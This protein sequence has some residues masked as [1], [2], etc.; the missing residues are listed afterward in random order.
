[1]ADAGVVANEVADQLENAADLT[2]NINKLDWRIPGAFG[3]GA[4]VGF[5]AGYYFGLRKVRKDIERDIDLKYALKLDQALKDIKQHYA[6]KHAEAMRYYR[7]KESDATSTTAA[8]PSPEEV[9]EAQGYS[10]VSETDVVD[11]AESSVSEVELKETKQQ[12]FER[13]HPDIPHWDFKDEYRKRRENGSPFVIHVDEYKENEK[14]HDQASWTYYE[15]DD[16][17]ATERDEVVESEKWL[18]TIGSE[19]LQRFGHGSNDVDVVYVRNEVLALDIEIIRN[20][21]N[22]AEIVHGLSKGDLKHS[23]ERGRKRRPR[24]DDD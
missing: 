6:E 1:M 24:F 21:G 4:A 22:Y 10:R 9:V 16:V 23:E 11:E 14:G 13:A 3:I 19:A 20:P 15:D 2:R 5:G 8:K 18:G 7:E 12:L 17:L